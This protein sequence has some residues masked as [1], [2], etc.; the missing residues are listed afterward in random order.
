MRLTDHRYSRDRLR[1]DLAL[2]FI[3]HEARTQTIRCWT[4]LTDDRIRKL[5]RSY[6][7]SDA[8]GPV[9]RHRGKSPQQAAFFM[10]NPR[11]QC[12]TAACAALLS[13][14]GVLPAQT[15]RDASRQIP[16]IIRGS[17]LCRAYEAFERLVPGTTISFEHA[18]Y[19]AVALSRADEL[20]ITRCAEC[21]ALNVVDRLALRAAHCSCCAACLPLPAAEMAIAQSPAAHIEHPPATR[22]PL[23]ARTR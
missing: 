3:Q 17:L 20:R 19:L 16:G 7:V 4:G 9:T 10:R 1:L 2:R 15:V 12:E 14:F 8:G 21:A 22:G 6:A 13:L 18:V 11:L 23:R 5:Y